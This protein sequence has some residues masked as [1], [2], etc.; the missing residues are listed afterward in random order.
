LNIRNLK[1]G[2]R[3]GAGFAVLLSLLLAIAVTGAVKIGATNQHVEN[4]TSNFLPS[5]KLINQ[6]RISTEMLRRLESQHLLLESAAQ[7]DEF[8]AR[9]DAQRSSIDKSL[10]D[11]EALLFDEQDARNLRAVQA[12]IQAQGPVWERLRALSRQAGNDPA[13]QHLA[14]KMLFTESRAAFGTAASSLDTLWAYNDELIIKAGHE[15]ADGYRSAVSL[16]ALLSLLAIALGAVMAV[17]ITRSIAQPLQQA[18]AVAQR[19]GAGDLSSSF[20]LTGRDETAHLLQALK[21][22][23]AG[24]VDIVSQ[25]R[26]SSDSIAIGSNEIANG[27]LDLSQ[28][29]EEQASNLQQ[30][31]ASMEQLTTTVKHNAETAAQAC[32]MASSASAVA[33]QGGVVVNQVVATMEQITSSSKRINDIIGVIDGIAFQTNILALNAAVEAAR[34]GEQGRGF[35]VVA[36]EVRSLAQ[37]SAA[38]AKEIKSLICVSVENVEAGARLCNDAGQTMGDIVQQVKRVTDL[39]TEISNSSMGQSTDIGQIGDA[40]NQLDQVT[41]QNAALVEQSAAAADSLRHQADQLAQTVAQ[42]K[43]G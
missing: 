9:I 41:Q 27:N 42:F 6:L 19:I 34:A 5:L 8:E 30:T 35:A 14:Q 39:I 4:F 18:V 11:Y 36:G 15:A 1:I 16:L 13:K 33:S 31:A 7:M 21:D 37:R 28:R 20:V 26:S 43:L 38:A 25:V 23:N 22:M 2:L 29:T 40:V 32:Q 12:A 17:W 3:L 10:K 24:L